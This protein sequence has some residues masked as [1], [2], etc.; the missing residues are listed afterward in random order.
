MSFSCIYTSQ[1]I[2]HRGMKLLKVWQKP[3]FVQVNTMADRIEKDSFGDVKVPSD[4][5]YGA[6]TVRSTVNFQIG[7]EYEKLPVSKI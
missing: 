1:R 3:W 2:A 6:Q 7:G 5:Y 4:K